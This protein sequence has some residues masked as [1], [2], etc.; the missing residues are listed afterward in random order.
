MSKSVLDLSATIKGPVSVVCE[1][2][3]ACVEQLR[4][5]CFVVG[6]VARDVIMGGYYGIQLR[7]DTRDV[8]FGIRVASWEQFQELK[9]KLLEKGAF[10]QGDAP[11]KFYYRQTG[12]RVDIIPYGGL[13]SKENTI[14]WPTRE[15]PMMNVT[16]YEDAFDC[17]IPVIV[18][19]A[20][21]LKMLFAS[22]VGLAILKLIAWNDNPA[23][24]KKDAEDVLYIISYYLD[25]GNRV[26]LAEDHADL[27]EEDGFDELRIG[28][29]LLGRDIT[30]VARKETNELLCG[31]LERES[32][33]ESD[34]R[35]VRDMKSGN[36]SKFEDQDKLAVL[37]ELL[38]GMGEKP[39]S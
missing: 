5:Q 19:S 30:N 6:A 18:K 37:K 12:I 35:L 23:L 20:P 38:A 21:P 2:I 34:L 39:G 17:A 10:R 28:A 15:L 33:P 1:P 16:G 7:S 14:T 22:P 25:L 3:A 4:T 11:H 9:E 32:D 31:I 8:D 26:R 29:R 13:A 24:R 27:L 36:L